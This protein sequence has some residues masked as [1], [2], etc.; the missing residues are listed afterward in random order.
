MSSFPC[1]DD[2]VRFSAPGKRAGVLGVVMGE[3]ALDCSDALFKRV[4]ERVLQSLPRELG[5]EALDGVHPGGRRRGEL[6]RPVETTF[7]PRVCFDG[8]VG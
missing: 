5:E 7:Q 6:E 2:V 4:E 8:F 1:L 3:V